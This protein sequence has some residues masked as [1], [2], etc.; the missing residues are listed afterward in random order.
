MRD[1]DDRRA[2]SADL[3]HDVEHLRRRGGVERAGRLVADD[4]LGVVDE[5]AA[6]ARPLELAARDLRDVARFELRY[7]H[8]RHQPASAGHDL[9]AGFVPGQKSRQRDVVEQAERAKEVRVLEDESEAAQ[10]QRRKV[11]LLHPGQ[12]FA[13]SLD[14]PA[15]GAVEAGEYVKEGRLSR[16]R[17]THD[18]NKRT[19]LY[20]HV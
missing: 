9:F 16:A 6:D 5:G 8:A 10:A 15:S 1:E 20:R 4:D 11:L 12:F 13:V 3:P 7:S 17:G 14:G 2:P 18:R 19:R